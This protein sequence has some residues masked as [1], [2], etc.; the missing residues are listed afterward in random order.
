MTKLEANLGYE[1]KNKELL[2]L[3]MSHSSFINEHRKGQCE[4]NERLEFLG[5]SVLSVIMSEYLYKNFP[6][7]PEGELT[8][9]RAAVV[10][11][12]TLASLARKLEIGSVILMG[13]GEKM[14]GGNDRDS[15][16]ADAFEALL[17]AVYLDS[18]LENVRFIYMPSLLTKI[19]GALKGTLNRDHKTYL[20]EIV[21]KNKEA[22]LEYVLIGESGP[23][24]N[25]TFTYEVRLDN[26]VIGTG[27][28]RSKKDAEQA[29]ARE[30]LI[31]MVGDEEEI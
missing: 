8:K 11:E 10:C 17:A 5:D 20:Q 2:T 14:H 7:L 25:K 30:A 12:K 4:S 27:S 3:A 19:E 28:G 23:D 29:A 16:L 1:F 15:I 13:R 24:H 26:N 18:D 31:L 6:D 22:F 9:I 21:Q